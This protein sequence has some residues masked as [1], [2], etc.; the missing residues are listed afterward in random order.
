MT[1]NFKPFFSAVFN[2]LQIDFT[3]KLRREFAETHNRARL[4]YMDWKENE[5]RP[6]ALR[7]E[8]EKLRKLEIKLA[9][10]KIQTPKL[11]DSFKESFD[12]DDFTS[13]TMPR[14]YVKQFLKTIEK[15]T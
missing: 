11:P 1:L 4:L 10:Y 13:S 12:M 6:A 7:T 3:K 8:L 2:F 15:Q 9:A 5:R 14:P